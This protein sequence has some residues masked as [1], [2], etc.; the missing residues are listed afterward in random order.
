MKTRT[1]KP[2]VLARIVPMLL[3]TL[4]MLAGTATAA[5]V[6]P[7]VRI[8]T[9]SY[10]DNGKVSVRGSALTSRI[11]E[12]GWLEAELGKRGVK[13]V[14]FPITPGDT[15]ASTNEAFASRRIDFANYGDLPSFTLNAGG[16]KTQVIVPSGPGSDT[17]LLVPPNSTDKSIV[18]L[19]GKRISLH[20]GR[21]WELGFLRLIDSHHLTYNDFKM[22]N[23]NPQAGASALSAGSVDALYTNGAL[24]L[25]EQGVGKIIWSTKDAP[26]DWKMRAELWGAAEFTGKYPELA[27]LVATAYVKAAYWASQ[28]ANRE[29]VIKIGTRNGTPESVVRRGYDDSGVSWKDRWNPLFD[30]VVHAHYRQAVAF[31]TQK[32]L[33]GKKLDPEQ[34]LEPKFLQAALKELKLEDYWKPRSLAGT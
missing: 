26:L 29:E 2:T 11:I 28:E 3:A 21:P 19:Q 34:L 17:Y 10:H 30:D 24:L 22:F 18:D 25:E 4:V 1:I 31:A 6:P 23:I 33:V 27:Q 16:I 14:W 7:E 12:E 13:L 20:R 15:G 5:E 8:A 9:S 32:K